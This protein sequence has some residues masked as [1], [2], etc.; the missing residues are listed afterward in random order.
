[1]GLSRA[2]FC[3]PVPPTR[4]RYAV[5]TWLCVGALIAYVPRNC[6]GV[7]EKTIRTDLGLEEVSFAGVRLS[8]TDQMGLV[9]SA[10]FFTYALLQLPAGWLAHVWGTRRALTWFALL[11]SAA[12]LLAVA[13]AGLPLLLLSRLGMGAAQAGIFACTTNTTA[14]WFPRTRRAVASGALG[15][16]MWVGGAA[17]AMLTGFLLALDINWRWMFVLYAVPGVVWA[18]GF[19]VWFR[20]HP[21]EHRSVNAAERDLLRDPTLG[22]AL[23][24]ALA[25][26]EPTP[27]RKLFTSPAMAWIC[28]QQFF[29]AAGTMFFASWFATYLQEARGVHVG[30][31][32]VLNSLPLWGVVLGS[33]AGG[34]TSDRVLAQTGSRRLARQGV[35][36]ASQLGCALLILLAYPVADVW[37]AVLL[38]SAGSFLAAFAGACAYTITIDMGGKHVATVFSLMNMAGNVGALVFP[39]VVPP[40]VRGVGWDA[41]LYGFAGIYVAGAL[42]WLG[43]NPERTVFEASR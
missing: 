2:P 37:L 33:L 15:G 4:V 30:E 38:I 34:V 9:M 25:H 13:A 3:S 14:H 16:F 12:T 28:A 7:A 21:D 1:M 17:A 11:W 31:A 8:A 42:C 35:A 32:G 39:L 41:V 27:W 19:Y 22:A 5:L 29:R 6:I 23:E 40:L 26:R 43:V 24:R 20:D 18:L 36:V 10:F